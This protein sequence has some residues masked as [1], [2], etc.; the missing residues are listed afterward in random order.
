MNNQ[1]KQH[2]LFTL[3]AFSTYMLSAQSYHAVSGSPY[4][5]VTSMY[6]NPSS[7]VNAAYKWDMSLLATQI[8]F[9]NSLFVVNQTSLIKYDS[10]DAQFTNGLRS[11]YLHTN[12]DINLFNFRYNIAKD[13]AI[14]FALRGRIYN[15]L[16]TQPFYYTDSIST[17]A[18]FLSANKVVDYLE[19]YTTHSGWIEADFNY[20]QVLQQNEYS[21]LT[22][23]ITIGYMRGISGAH[24][25]FK[26]LSYSE[27]TINNQTQY[28]L[29]G[30]SA[31]VEYSKNYDLL[32]TVF[33]AN[34]IKPFIKNTKSA[35]T[36]NIG[37]E[38]LFKKQDDYD[39]APLSATNYDW[40]IGISIMDIGA[41]KFDPAG[42]SFSGRIPATNIS[43]SYL[44]N[45][46]KN[47]GSLK[48][49]R[50]SLLKVFTKMDTLTSTYTISNPT[51]LIV[52]ID[53]NLGNHF[54]IN[55]ELSANFY[56]TQTQP[57]LKTREINLLTITPRWETNFWGA[58]LPIQYNAQGQ[59]WVG[60]AIK[61]G[62]IL[63]GFHSLDAYKAFKTR[64]QT[65]N[66]G[67]YLVV[68][69]H[70]F[71]NK[72]KEAECPPF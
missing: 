63:F 1:I 4:A 16:K 6:N 52:S 36:L 23:G 20:A 10:A 31:M 66:G 51:R 33:T 56:S 68:N 21:R 22:G 15:H 69:I 43:D 42:G 65:F 12:L 8:T 32:D 41:N 27:Q 57:K 28:V 64:T 37:I 71:G 34:D 14:G 61:V 60:G 11:R 38:Y 67:F 13:K 26:R 45:N 62:P 19:G 54:Y 18:S 53:K 55:G 39:K 2:L 7:T 9:S 17:L 29:T 50:D 35:F 58:Y 47:V 40:K 5:G 59:L 30:G 49:L 24:I 72:I 46:L 48:S 25:N 3:L 44:V 70:P